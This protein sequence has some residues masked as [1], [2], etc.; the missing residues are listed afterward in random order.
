MRYLLPTV[1]ALLTVNACTANPPAVSDS[2]PA[3]SET[4]AEQPQTAEGWLEAIEQSA[5][6]LHTLTAKLRYDR[7][8]LLLGDHQ[9]RFGTLTYQAGP[10]PKFV[11]H[12]DRLL[13]DDQ[14]SEPDLRY[15]YDGRWLLKRD[16][17]NKTAVRYQLVPDGQEAADAMELGEG[18]FPV[19]LNLK[20]DA[21]L[22]R[23]DV[24]LVSFEEGD[25][26]NS[27][28]LLLTPHE[29]YPTELTE[30]EFWFDRGT[31]LPQQVKSTDDSGNMTVVLLL[32]TQVN[33]ELQEQTFDTQLPT[34]PGWQTDENRIKTEPASE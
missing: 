9:R 13:V 30:I 18:P 7:D 6:D 23:F 14:W 16:Q 4:Q 3:S 24:Q 26:E 33:P 19:P 28:H 22:Q 1:F 15:I 32:E 20:K 34:E 10:P 12:F 21:V 8:Q 17:E 29:D 2:A 25:P 11:A 31:R 27:V 5:A